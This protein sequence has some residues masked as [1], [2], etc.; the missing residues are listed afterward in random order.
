M[1]NLL[2]RLGQ[3]YLAI[4]FVRVI[5]SWVFVFRPDWRPPEGIRPAMSLIYAVVDP[6][7]TYLRRLIPPLGSGGIGIDIAFIVWAL[8]IAYLVVPMLCRLGF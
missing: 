2:C 6:P 1:G 4:L 3:L 7:V 5:L 8:F